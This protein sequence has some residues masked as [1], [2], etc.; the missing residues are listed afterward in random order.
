MQKSKRV[1]NITQYV[2]TNEA[3]SLAVLLVSSFF[4]FEWEFAQWGF[5]S[6]VICQGNFL[7]FH[8]SFSFYAFQKYIYKFFE[9]EEHE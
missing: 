6:L 2:E 9:T 8:T 3:T 7:V 5:F 1:I 4:S